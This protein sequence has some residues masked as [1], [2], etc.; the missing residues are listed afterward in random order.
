MESLIDYIIE[1]VFF[2]LLYDFAS[3]MLA[4]KHLDLREPGL[5]HAI[6]RPFLGEA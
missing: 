3:S 4:T 6:G 5:R 1:T 2:K